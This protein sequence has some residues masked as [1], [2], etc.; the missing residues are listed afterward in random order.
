[1]KFEHFALNVPDAAALADWYVEH[2]RMRI[3][4]ARSAPPTR[5]LADASGRVVMEVYTNPDAPI[6]DYASQPSLRFHFAFA[7]AD[8]AADAERLC[9]EGASVEKEETLDDG[10][11]LI[12]LRDPWGLPL[13]L[14]R[15]TTLL[16]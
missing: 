6:P 2:C 1:M 11:L 4:I 9:R 16:V 13:Q 15:R 3:V 14:C 12:T 5:F 8:P 7:V 10:S